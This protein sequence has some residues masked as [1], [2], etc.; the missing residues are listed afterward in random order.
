MLKTFSI[1]ALCFLSIGLLLVGGL[2]LPGL[3]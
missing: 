2:P 3:A 1:S